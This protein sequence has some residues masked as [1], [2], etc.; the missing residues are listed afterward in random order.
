MVSS[1]KQHLKGDLNMTK[2]NTINIASFAN[3]LGAQATK[4]ALKV[5]K[6]EYV[7]K[8]V[9]DMRNDVV[10][11][12]KEALNELQNFTAWDKKIKDAQ[13]SNRMIKRV[14]GGFNFTIGTGSRNERISSTVPFGVNKTSNELTIAM[15]MIEA[16]INEANNGMFDAPLAEKLASYRDRAEKGKEARIAQS[17]ANDLYVAAE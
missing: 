5:G 13:F 17:Q 11:S 10:E 14:R 6:Q 3:Q 12:M 7:A 9:S 4:D 8:T 16:M 2:V 1:H 15:Q